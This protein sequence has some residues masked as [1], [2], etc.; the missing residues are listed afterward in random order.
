MLRLKLFHIHK[1]DPKAQLDALSSTF[2]NPCSTLLNACSF[3]GRF[4]CYTGRESGIL[5]FITIMIIITILS[6]WPRRCQTI[7]KNNTDCK[8]NIFSLHFRRLLLILR[9]YFITLQWR[10]SGRDSVSNHQPR[11]CLLSR[12]IRRRWKK[13][14]NLCVTGLCAGKSPV[15]G[16]FPAQMSSDAEKFS[17]WWRHHDSNI[18][19]Y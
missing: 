18:F 11:N 2:K 6:L 1:T 15:T 19:E 16:E 3:N 14:P 12:L 9:R 17:I 8:I 4:P 5:P 10:H 7:I 13:T